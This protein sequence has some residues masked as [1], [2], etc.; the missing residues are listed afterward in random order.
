MSDN[1]YAEGDINSN[2]KGSG[3]RSNLG[4]VA[5]SLMPLHLLAGATRV[6]MAGTLKYVHW[7]WA[8]GMKWSICFDCILRHLIKWFYLGEDC[9]P[10]TGEHHLDYVLCNVLFLKH[11]SET[12][13]EGDDRP[14]QDVTA[15][16]EWMDDIQQRFDEQAFLERNPEIKAIVEARRATD[17]DV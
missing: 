3:A 9:D 13:K 15:F 8:K 14:P 10:E 12:Y 16:A 4:K 1:F 11:Y 5:F 7:N 6:L 17:A 2:V